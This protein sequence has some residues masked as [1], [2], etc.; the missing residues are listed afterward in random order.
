MKACGTLVAMKN[1][2]D[3]LLTGLGEP[4]GI[5]LDTLLA[6]G[7]FESIRRFLLLAGEGQAQNAARQMLLD[8]AAHGFVHSRDKKKMYRLGVYGWPVTLLFSASVRMH[9][10]FNL[11]REVMLKLRSLWERAITTKQ[12]PLVSPMSFA[13]HLNSLLGLSPMRLRQCTNHGIALIQGEAMHKSWRFDE[14]PA[15]LEDGSPELPGTYIFGTYAI[16]DTRDGEPKVHLDADLVFQFQQLV[17]GLF[18]AK[19]GDTVKAFVG[20]PALFHSAITT[21]QQLQIAAMKQ[22]AARLEHSLCIEMAQNDGRFN[23]RVGYVDA[24]TQEQTIACAWDYTSMWRP[25]CHL[26]QLSVDEEVSIAGRASIR[27]RE[28]PS[29]E[30]VAYSFCVH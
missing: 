5:S 9:T 23:V 11:S 2:V 8:K 19:P 22:R 30:A 26:L 28:H 6:H 18:S 21:A 12:Q 1:P 17:Q 10:S 14:E 13:S 29:S 7:D 16:W 4:H 27:C 24:A 3:P 15:G 20:R 25:A